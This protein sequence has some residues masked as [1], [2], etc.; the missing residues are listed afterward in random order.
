M[1]LHN[2]LRL[3][4][5]DRPLDQRVVMHNRW[6][7]LLFLHWRFDPAEIQATLPPGLIVDTFDGLAWVGVVPFGM[8]RIRPVYLPSVPGIS[9]FLE[10]NLRKYVYDERTGIPGVWF[11][12]LDASQ[13]LA[14]KVARRFFHLPYFYAKMTR[15]REQDGWILYQSQMGHEPLSKIYYQPSSDPLRKVEPGTL[16]FFLLERY[17]LFS[18]DARQKQL[19][20]GRVHHTP[21]EFTEVKVGQ[22]ECGSL[23]QRADLKAPQTEAESCLYAPFVQTLIFPLRKAALTL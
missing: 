19:W 4:Q 1:E 16:E 10:M 13:W 5:R 8:E 6:T 17:V 23:F 3:V 22:Q 14:C 18:W 15:R 7:D 11:F 12:S 2:E 20:L 21:Y 9:W